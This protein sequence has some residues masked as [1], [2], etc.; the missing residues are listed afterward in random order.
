MGNTVLR[1]GSN[2][3]KYLNFLCTRMTGNQENQGISQNNTVGSCVLKW[4]EGGLN[5]GIDVLLWI[6]FALGEPVWT[7]DAT[8][9]HCVTAEL[10]RPREGET[11]CLWASSH[12]SSIFTCVADIQ[13]G[14]SDHT[15]Y[16]LKHS[17]IQCYGGYWNMLESTTVVRD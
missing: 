12:L 16:K 8:V 2:I 7:P 14:V 6:V 15:H 5:W 3:T 10:K 9:C 1:Q 17:K 11:V 13:M 4:Q